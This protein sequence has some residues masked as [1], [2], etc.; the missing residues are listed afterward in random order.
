MRVRLLPSNLSDPGRLQPLTTFLLDGTVAID[1]GSL[2][3]ALNTQDQLRVREIVITHS[4]N[5]HIASLPIFVAEVFPFLSQPVV[6]HGTHEV[7]ESL[8]AH[9]FNDAIWPDF[10]TI[11]LTHGDGPGLRYVEIEAGVP[12]DLHGMRMTPIAVNHVVPTVALAVEGRGAT[13]LF[14][15]DTY[16]T[17][18][19]W[20]AANRLDRLD[21]VFV[22]VSY[23]NEMEELAA[24]SKH[25]TPQGLNLEL[26]KLTRRAP[27]YAYHLK[28]Q[29]RE[30]VIAQ[31]VGLGRPDV[32]VAEIGRDYVFGEEKT[33]A[34]LPA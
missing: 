26:A 18:E 28:P 7:I 2:G 1:G 20:R 22:D 5:D 34:I 21:A 3:Y 27:V 13:V 8:R 23:P 16:H 9:V 15:S 17:E 10:H 6:V 29:F 11:P 24:A 12:F 33:G 25:L 14:T 30:R 4:H 31:L 32:A 19:V